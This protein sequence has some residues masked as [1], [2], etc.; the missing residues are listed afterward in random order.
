MADYTAAKD[1]GFRY[2]QLLVYSPTAWY[3]GIVQFKRVGPEMDVLF[4]G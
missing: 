1:G 2:W 3:N 4:V